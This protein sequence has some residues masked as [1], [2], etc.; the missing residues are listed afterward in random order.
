VT[1][2]V[3]S[4]LKAELPSRFGI[5][6]DGWTV[7]S[8]HYVAVFASYSVEAISQEGK[9]IREARYPL[10]SLS[11]FEEETSFGAENHCEYLHTVLQ[12]YNRKV[13]DVLFLVADNCPTNKKVAEI[14][15]VYF[16]GCFSHRFNL[17]VNLYLASV[18]SIIIKVEGVM[19]KLRTLKLAGQ[20]RQKNH[21]RA[22][23]R[24]VT[25][26]SSTYKMT[27][28][29]LELLTSILELNNA[30]VNKM[31]PSL[32]EIDEIRRLS[33]TLDELNGVTVALQSASLNLLQVRALFDSV[34]D[35]YSGAP[36]FAMYL[37]A[38][39]EIV[40]DCDRLFLSGIC[41]IVAGNLTELTENE[42]SACT[43][44]TKPER[45]IVEK[46]E[47]KLPTTLAEKA[48]QSC[49]R[50]LTTADNCLNENKNLEFINPTSNM[51]ER[52]FSQ[53][54]NVLRDQRSSLLPINFESAIF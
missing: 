21:L 15:R 5:V 40:R 4:A 18:E 20:L 8:T 22:I 32:S 39:S 1:Q 43:L 3:E 6:L 31:M 48:L 47:E 23:L 30:D 28:R 10:L 7:Q 45:L 16:I 25:R 49:K 35:T 9:I 26:W 19:R 42:K 14:M 41:K 54:K 24:N 37:R 11:P 34:L 13:S 17:A 51:V 50:R 27:K 53:C 36:A 2:E 38:T 52:L 33:T 44:F 12:M 46:A 29:F